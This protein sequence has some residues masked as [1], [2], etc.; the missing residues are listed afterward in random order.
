VAAAWEVTTRSGGTLS[1]VLDRVGAGLR[2]EEEARAEL[3]SHLAPARA[4]AK[5]LAALPVFGLA[6]GTSMGAHPLDVLLGSGLGLGCLAVG[7]GLAGLG[8]VWVDRL[9]RAIEA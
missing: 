3:S 6:L 4:T 7:M 2:D 1:D 8:V 5:L 9:A